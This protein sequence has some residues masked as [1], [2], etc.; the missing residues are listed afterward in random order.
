MDSTWR[1]ITHPPSPG[2]WNMA[3]DDLLLELASRGPACLRHYPWDRPTLS[4]G[5]VAGGPMTESFS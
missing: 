4:L 2:D 5:Y 1:L 3:V